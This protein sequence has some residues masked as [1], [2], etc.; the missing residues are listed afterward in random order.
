M[1]ELGCGRG[2]RSP[3]RLDYA[4]DVGGGLRAI[5]LDTADRAGGADG[6]V[7]EAQVKWLRKQLAEARDRDVVVLSH[8]RIGGSGGSGRAAVAALDAS[9]NVI[10][11]FD[12]PCLDHPPDQGGR[13]LAGEAREL[14]YLDSQGGR[15]Q[16]RAG[17]R[18]HRNVRLYL[19]A[20]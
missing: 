16:G 4:F 14:A 2:L 15:P 20:R 3:E 9:P 7:S 17:T 6:V 12:D 18:M 5:V 11:T 8:Q 10:A 1:A 19:P 13:G